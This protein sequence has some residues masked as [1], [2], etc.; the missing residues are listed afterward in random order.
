M[1]CTHSHGPEVLFP[2]NGVP[3][4]KTKMCFKWQETGLCYLG[5]Q[6][7][8]AHGEHELYGGNGAV[9][10]GGEQ[11]RNGEQM[12][13][14]NVATPSVSN[15]HPMDW[16]APRQNA[17]GSADS[18]SD[19]GYCGDAMEAQWLEGQRRSQAIN[20]EEEERIRLEGEQ[21]YQT[22]MMFK[23]QKQYN[24]QVQNQAMTLA[25][26]QL[27][28][29]QAEAQA[30]VRAVEKQKAREAEEERAKHAEKQEAERM[31]MRKFLGG[32]LFSSLAPE[33]SP[34]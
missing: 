28:Q 18:I 3:Y 23:A 33:F 12:S 2:T 22:Y 25:Q 29:Q 20:T 5:S 31:F 10:G 9:P 32:D 7:K 27:L 26:Q 30:A 21:Q 19:Q 13:W 8:F 6:C 24:M 11:G 17:W 16:E 15:A 4:Y 1:D 14:R 34:V